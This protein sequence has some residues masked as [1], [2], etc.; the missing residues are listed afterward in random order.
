M[1]WISQVLTTGN[2]CE[3]NIFKAVR[4]VSLC[5]SSPATA[6]QLVENELTRSISQ[7]PE[8]RSDAQDGTSS[9]H[10]VN[11]SEEI[12]DIKK[13]TRTIRCRNKQSRSVHLPNT[14]ETPLSRPSHGTAYALRLW[15]AACKSDE[16]VGSHPY[17]INK[18]ITWAAGAARGRA[19]GAIIGECADCLVVPIRSIR[20]GKIQGVECIAPEGENETFGCVDGGAL[21][22]GNSMAKE[23]T[24]YLVKGW[25]SAVSIV[26]HHNQQV[27]V[28]SFGEASQVSI[29]QQISRTYSPDEIVILREVAL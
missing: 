11:R 12:L 20:S 4:K 8:D 13:E 29:A 17:A 1:L 3:P 28:C 6:E 10:D 16:Y 21:I 27:A 26:F 15:L 22:L 23:S 19:S 18:G 7:D 24:W 2:T 14:R 25:A 5:R 9:E